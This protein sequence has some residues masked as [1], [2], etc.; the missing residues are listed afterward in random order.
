MAIPVCLENPQLVDWE[1]DDS[2]I[3]IRAE[4]TV[5]VPALDPQDDR[6]FHV[7]ADATML[8]DDLEIGQVPTD[9]VIKQRL[10]CLQFT[11]QEQG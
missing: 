5:Y 3:Y 1:V 9:E 11:V 8:I 6:E 10:D 7:E 4:G 2:T